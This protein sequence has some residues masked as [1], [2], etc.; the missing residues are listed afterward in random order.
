MDGRNYE[1]PRLATNP[2]LVLRRIARNW[3]FLLWL[4]VLV[5]I[6][7]V[8]SRNQQFGRMAGTVEIIGE[9]IV[10]PE[11]ARLVSLHVV[12]GQ[13]VTN[14]Q[15]VA[16]MDTGSVDAQ[17]RV[18]E[19]T[20][21]DARDAFSLD[22]RAMVA[23]IEKSEAAVKD[24]EATLKTQQ[25]L[26]ERDAAEVA[27]LR[28]EL[29]RRE[30]LLVKRLIDEISV[31]ELRPPIASLE[32][33]LT[34]YPKLIE[35]CRQALKSAE[36][37]RD[38]MQACL[39]MDQDGSLSGA[40]SNKAVTSLSIVEA[41]RDQTRQRK[42]SFT[43]RSSRAGIVSRI[44]IFPGNVVPAGIPIMHIVE[45]HPTTVVG[46]SP[47]LSPLSLKVGQDVLIWR[48]NEPA[49]LQ[50]SEPSLIVP[51]VVE[52]VSTAVEAFPARINP[53]QVQVQ[54]GEPLRGRRII[55]RFKGEHD[56]GARAFNPGETVEIREVYEGWFAG[57]DRL[58]MWLSGRTVSPPASTG[59]GR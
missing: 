8:Y 11:A 10:P 26:Q 27:E 54:G 46:F 33:G 40:I 58:K 35:I 20:L 36:K 38:A 4:G 12:V 50:G 22:Q 39:R 24:A 29:K 59:G 49:F 53:I 41:T 2:R 17:M 6:M 47:E 23:A 9:E 57:L 18:D 3:P 7:A 44:Y 34:S 37:H 16:Q 19:A 31:N 32:Q 15:I 25:M 43:L 51:A 52:S 55:F 13:S 28:R 5:F 48:Q 30:D 56:F 14:G 45:P 42:Q 1:K 21:R